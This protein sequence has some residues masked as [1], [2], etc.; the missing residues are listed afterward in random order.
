M[1]RM[2]GCLALKENRFS[3]KRERESWRNRNEGV[4]KVFGVMTSSDKNLD[5][6]ICV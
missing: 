3:F 4:G 5:Y 2:F 1:S 6:S